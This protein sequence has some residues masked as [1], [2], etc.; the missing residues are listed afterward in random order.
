MKKTIIKNE[1]RDRRH[2]RIR[3]QIFG[4]QE[5][6]RLSVF[7]SNKALYGQLIDDETGTTLASVQTNIKDKKS[8]KERAYD[9]G[10][11]IAD[12]AKGKKIT[13]VVFDRG[14]FVYAGSVAS[15]AQGA[16]EG[17]MSF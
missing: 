16:R 8:P 10:K 3:S 4:T 2:K 17:G 9:A 5:R 11:D 13:K 6:P 1:R 14:G 7:R 15:F 12:K